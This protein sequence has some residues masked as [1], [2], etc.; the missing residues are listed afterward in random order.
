MGVVTL[1]TG[2]VGQDRRSADR[3]PRPSGPGGFA[4]AASRD[5]WDSGPS[6]GWTGRSVW[7]CH[8]CLLPVTPGT[9]RSAGTQDR[10]GAGGGVGAGVSTASLGAPAAGPGRRRVPLRAPCPQASR[11]A[12]ARPADPGHPSSAS[13][14]PTSPL[15]VGPALAAAALPDLAARSR[16]HSAGT[17][18]GRLPRA[19]P[20]PAPT[21]LSAGS[22]SLPR[23]RLC[24]PR[25][26]RRRPRHI[27]S[28]CRSHVVSLT[29]SPESPAAAAGSLWLVTSNREPFPAMS[30][31]L[32]SWPS[33]KRGPWA[34]RGLGDVR[35]GG[36][37]VKAGTEGT[38][39]GASESTPR[40]RAGDCG[41]RPSAC[42]RGPHRTVQGAAPT[43]RPSALRAQAG[44]ACPET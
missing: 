14:P 40:P 25:S 37:S 24:S 18:Q 1:G 30:R 3:G 10:P 38:L 16:P 4:I 17:R 43:R 22:A 13:L 29:D 7:P 20:P 44:T 33:A 19:G 42:S 35:R 41:P 31:A 34:P 32:G 2:A 6:R 27:R 26:R 8:H 5:P 39:G 23:A 36:R 28:R 11:S 21:G 12:E 9:L 15:P